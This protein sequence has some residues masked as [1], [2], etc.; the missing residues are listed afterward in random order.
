[1]KCQR[2]GTILQVR[3][4]RIFHSSEEL[5]DAVDFRTRLQAEIS[6]K[7]RET[8][9]LE[10]SAKDYKLSKPRKHIDEDTE[11]TQTSSL[12][13]VYENLPS[14]KNLKSFFLDLLESSGG[15]MIIEEFRQKALEK[16]ISPEKF[17]LMLK[18]TLEKGEIYSPEAGIIKLV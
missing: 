12:N 11:K 6:G 14:N 1:M 5:V 3:R 13:A 9:S 17:D 4:L 8:F 15:K 18:K 2:C 16:G 7:G 10:T